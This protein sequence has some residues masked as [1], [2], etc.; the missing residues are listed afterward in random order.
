MAISGRKYTLYNGSTVI[1]TLYSI[2]DTFTYTF[3]DVVF[4]TLGNITLSIY[5]TPDFTTSKTLVGTFTVTIIVNPFITA[6][7]SPTITTSVVGSKQLT[8][9]FTEPDLSG[10]MPILGYKYSTN[11]GLSYTTIPSTARQ[12]VIS[13]IPSQNSTVLV[14]A[15]N[16]LGDSSYV[17]VVVTMYSTPNPPTITSVVPG[18]SQVQVYFTPGDM[19]FSTFAG[20]KYS[21][22]GVN[23]YWTNETT[24]PITITGLTVGISYNITLKCVS[25]NAGTSVAS[26]QSASFTPYSLPF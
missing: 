15:Y 8:V 25:E 24:S 1:S 20:Y 9:N 12:F 17:E 16:V 18:T 26:T 5:D 13:D 10:G 7:S 21:T 14:K 2:N 11:L 22:D 19:N 6:P 4:E 3:S 23:Y